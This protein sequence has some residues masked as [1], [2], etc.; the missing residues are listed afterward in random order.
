MSSRLVSSLTKIPLKQWPK[1][2]LKR[3]AF[4]G[5]SRA[6][7]QLSMPQWSYKGVLQ[8][9]SGQKVMAAAMSA[10]QFDPSGSTLYVTS[11]QFG[12]K[13]IPINPVNGV[14]TCA[15]PL[16]F[17]AGNAAGLV[18]R[19]NDLFASYLPPDGSRHMWLRRFSHD[20]KGSTHIE[21]QG[22]GMA[23]GAL[24]LDADGRL[25]VAD[26]ANYCIMSYRFL[27]G[28]SPTSHPSQALTGAGLQTIDHTRYLAFSSLT[29]DKLADNVIADGERMYTANR[30]TAVASDSAGRIFIANCD[31]VSGGGPPG[32]KFYVQQHNRDHG[33]INKWLCSKGPNADQLPGGPSTLTIAKDLLYVGASNAVRIFATESGV[34]QGGFTVPGRGTVNCIATRPSDNYVFVGDDTQSCIHVFTPN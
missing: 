14:Q 30:P 8:E 24:G 34:F 25:L 20:G 9:Q 12:I 5:A 16:T 15:P 28:C 31:G 10:M 13:A 33:A 18:V 29:A 6:F 27:A 32:L 4:F 1:N 26:W 19:D 11:P 21:P 22:V 7:S 3:T 2:A 23:A 17:G